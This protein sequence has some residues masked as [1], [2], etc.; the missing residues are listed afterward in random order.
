MRMFNMAT[1]TQLLKYMSFSFDDFILEVSELIIQSNG[2]KLP[3]KLK[4]KQN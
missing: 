3:E 1:K 2:N 4:I